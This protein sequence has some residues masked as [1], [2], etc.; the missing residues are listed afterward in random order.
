M[1]YCMADIHG[2]A[3]RFDQMLRLI[4]L[5]P[6]DTLY[7]IGDVIDRGKEGI[8]LLRRIMDTSNMILLKG[9]HEQMCLDTLGPHNRYGWKAIWTQNGGGPTYRELVYKTPPRE[10]AALLQFLAGCPHSLDVTVNG[11]SFHLVHGFPSQDPE[12][13]L[14]LRPTPDAPP[15]FSDRTAIVG[16]TPTCF[17]TGDFTTPLSIWEGNGVIDIDCGCGSDSSISRLACLRLD[18]LQAFYI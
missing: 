2:R 3:Q 12:E 15:P 10:R 8:P 1:T 13:Q 17:L 9:N 5:S 4:S 18:D 11:R 6:Q 7:I 14:W 16:H